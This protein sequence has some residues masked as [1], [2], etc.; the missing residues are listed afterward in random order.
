MLLGLLHIFRAG[1]TY[2]STSEEVEVK[3]MMK[4]GGSSVYLRN[5]GF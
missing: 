1:S 4:I 3:K 5:L 2:F